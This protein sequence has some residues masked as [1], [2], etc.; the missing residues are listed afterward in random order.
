MMK[1]TLRLAA[2]ECARYAPLFC[3]TG[4]DGCGK[5]TQVQRLARR[6]RAAGWPTVTVWTGGQKTVTGALV[7]L[8]QRYLHA[9]RR[10]AD[11]RFLAPQGD[12]R[13]L[14]AEFS[15]YLTSSHRLFQRHR[16]LGRSW[17]DVSIFE[18][19]LEIDLSVLPHL[20]CKRAVVC[21]RYLYRSVVNAAVLLDISVS[22]V[23]HLL[24][25]PA[26]CLVP[27]PTIYFLLD[28]KAEVAY[29]RKIDLPS[30]EYV[31]RRV[32][33]YRA[34]AALTGMTVIDGGQSPD[35]VE[36]FVWAHVERALQDLSA[37]RERRMALHVVR[38]A[39][40]AER[41]QQR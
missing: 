25:H 33:L 4:I 17:L 22:E 14:A 3:F 1:H 10:G 29:R 39:G 30:V 20:F 2:S 7:R 6:L 21:D 40:P 11:R 9:P 18:H 19:M 8:G 28:M 15:Q 38:R 26:L 41:E 35:T 27:R 31:E 16:L 23:P 24:R 34:I 12:Q 36:E 37:G 5:S 13:A 32:P